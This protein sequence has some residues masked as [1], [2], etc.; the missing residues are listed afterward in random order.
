[1]SSGKKIFDFNSVGD[2]L[3]QLR[4]H[5]LDLQKTRK[6]KKVNYSPEVPLRLSGRQKEL[7]VMNTDASSA[8]ANNLAN[9]LK[10]NRGER[11]MDVNFGANLRAI[12]AEYGVDGFEDEVMVRIKTAV[13]AYMSYINLQTMKI[14]KLPSSPASGVIKVRVELGYS[15]QGNASLETMSVVL[16][17]IA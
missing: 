4:N 5:E 7:F 8:I 14:Q 13:A 16:G 9:L 15:I 6:K 17:T 12:L 3:P 10:T 2:R 11:V 1:M